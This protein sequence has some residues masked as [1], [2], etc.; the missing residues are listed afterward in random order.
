MNEAGQQ[1]DN[2][3]KLRAELAAQFQEAATETGFETTTVAWVY[4]Q[5]VA[6]AEPPDGNEKR[7]VQATPGEICERLIRVLNDRYPG[8]LEP[9][10]VDCNIRNGEDFGR[11]VRA[12]LDRQLLIA[13]KCVHP[14]DF[15]GIFETQNL[16]AFLKARGI[17]KR[18]AD[19]RGIGG[20]L[21]WVCYVAGVLIVFGNFVQAPHMP[22]AWIG[23]LVG[24]AG[25]VMH[26]QARAVQVNP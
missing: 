2:E 13:P 14:R 16:N 26:W 5:T 23:W 24:V 7:T 10:L 21:C 8:G 18:H 22:P 17:K 19:W 3:G 20:R 11:I 6:L 4:H 1:K 9:V 12:L 15:D 25:G